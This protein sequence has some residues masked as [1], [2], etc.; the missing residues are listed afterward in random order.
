MSHLLNNT[1]PLSENQVTYID[2]TSYSRS[3]ANINKDPRLKRIHKLLLNW[4]NSHAAN[5]QKIEYTDKQLAKV[6]NESVR[7]IQRALRELQAMKI[8]TRCMVGVKRVIKLMVVYLFPDSKARP[9]T[10]KEV[11]TS[12]LS[13]EHGQPCPP[14][15]TICIN[16]YKQTHTTREAVAS[17]CDSESKPNQETSDLS[18]RQVAE[19]LCSNYPKDAAPERVAK[20]LE[21]ETRGMDTKKAILQ[22]SGFIAKQKRDEWCSKELRYVPQLVNLIKKGDW[23]YFKLTQESKPNQEITKKQAKEVKPSLFEGKYGADHARIA[24]ERLERE[25]KAHAG[26]LTA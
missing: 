4:L 23:K 11:G 12:A 18:I 1:T 10:P 25:R 22:L 9:S 8:L 3:S 13:I 16:N 6:F 24:A 14:P 2:S 20:A 21:Q 19:K 5:N 7:E 15:T 17:V 26:L